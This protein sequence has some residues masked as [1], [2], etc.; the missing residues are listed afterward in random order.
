MFKPNMSHI[1]I[2]DL[3]VFPISSIILHVV[4]HMYKSIKL[5]CH[6]SLL[7]Y[8]RH[9]FDMADTLFV[10]R[11]KATMSTIDSHASCSC[12]RGPLLIGWHP[13]ASS[14]SEVEYPLAAWSCIALYTH[15]HFLV[16]QLGLLKF[17]YVQKTNFCFRGTQK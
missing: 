8:K 10:C 12:T 7:V 14:Q 6:L 5:D 11:V 9:Y 4:I 1:H 3:H 15:F 17:R 16:H 13:G 2:E